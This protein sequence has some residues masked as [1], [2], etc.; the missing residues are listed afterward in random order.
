MTIS[1]RANSGGRVHDGR[2]PGMFVPLVRSVQKLP[3]ATADAKD[4][5]KT[6][7]EVLAEHAPKT[8]AATIEINALAVAWGGIAGKFG[9]EVRKSLSSALGGMLTAQTDFKTAWTEF[10][11]GLKRAWR[12]AVTDILDNFLEGFLKPAQDGLVGLGVK[13]AEWVT[14]K[15]AI[16]IT[17][18]GAA[19]GAAAGAEAG[20]AAEAAKSVTGLEKVVKALPKAIGI[21]A[22]AELIGQ[23]LIAA[24]FENVPTPSRL[25]TAAAGA[26]SSA[27]AAEIRLTGKLVSNTK[28]PDEAWIALNAEAWA[29]TRAAYQ[30]S[31]QYWE[32]SESFENRALK[33]LHPHD[34]TVGTLRGVRLTGLTEGGAVIPTQIGLN[35]LMNGGLTPTDLGVD[36]RWVGVG[37]GTQR[38]YMA[39][40]GGLYFEAVDAA[41]VSAAQG[42]FIE[43]QHA[44][45]QASTKTPLAETI[46]PPV[47]ARPTGSRTETTALTYPRVQS[48]AQTFAQGMG[49]LFGEQ[50]RDVAGKGVFD[51]MQQ[52]SLA[53]GLAS[54][55]GQIFDAAQSMGL[56]LGSIP[57]PGSDKTFG[58]LFSFYGS[59]GSYGTNNTN[60]ITVNV[61]K[62]FG[63]D[64]E[65][66]QL[67]DE[68]IRIAR[69]EGLT[70]NPIA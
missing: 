3:T 16:T 5:I 31:V 60:L 70:L 21:V 18:G 28:V 39:E 37:N 53:R 22:G 34:R 69:Q 52:T 57:I 9:E 32:V 61:D 4:A 29:K 44:A 40:D 56:S 26:F 19:A 51:F 2:R 66:R 65:M 13:A 59:R 47:S 50:Q 46:A 7:D 63:S 27:G 6:L 49:V 23:V 41:A 54:V 8:T 68:I 14:G 24:G 38:A 33:S 64:A 10:T 43:A 45:G 15:P 67:T 20:A 55:Q 35:L 11:D 1:G 42:A 48:M 62:F 58:D 12:G 30:T 25:I 17:P 36:P